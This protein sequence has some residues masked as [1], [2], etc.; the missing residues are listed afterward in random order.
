[1]YS[2][3]A[4]NIQKIFSAVS[5]IDKLPRMII[6][7]G[8]R[9]FLVLFA[10]GTGLVVWNHVKLNYDPYFE[11]VALSVVKASF[12]VLAEAVIG[13]LLIDFIFKKN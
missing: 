11:F 2:D 9:A 4:K 6:K 8:T 1:M 5:K 10:I 13:G 7:Y 12:T 3:L